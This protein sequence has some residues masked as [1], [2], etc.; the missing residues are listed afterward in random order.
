MHN[1]HVNSNVKPL[2]YQLPMDW[3]IYCLLSFRN[4]WDAGSQSAK[5]RLVRAGVVPAL[6]CWAA[7]LHLS[8]LGFRRPV[9]YLV[10][11]CPLCALQPGTGSAA[12]SWPLY[13]QIWVIPKAQKSIYT[14]CAVN[15]CHMCLLFYI[16]Y[17]ELKSPLKISETSED[18]KV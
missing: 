8:E 17:W 5:G 15:S 13:Q 4:S 14:F 7:D 11:C 3:C 12:L 9:S 6:L 16:T 18:L 1:N 10:A 2:V